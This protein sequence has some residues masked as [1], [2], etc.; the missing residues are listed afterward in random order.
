MADTDDDGVEEIE[1]AEELV[2]RVAA[3]DIAKASGMVCVRVPHEDKPGKRVQRVFNT[4]A[5]SGAI[6]DLADHLICQGVTRVVME[7]TS[8]YWKPFFFLLE[9]RGLEC[10]LVNARDVKNVPGRPKTDHLD[11]VWL[12]KLTERG[13]LR[14]S[15]VPPKPVRELRDLTRARAVMTQERTRPK[16]RTEKLLEDAQIKL[17]TVI[18][19]IFGVSGRAMLEALIAGERSPK[20]LA[21]LAHGTIKASHATLAESLTGRFEEHHAFMCRMLLDTVD[22][23]TVQIDKLTARITLRLT[24]LSTTEDDEGPGQGTLI[25]ITDTE[26]LDEIPGI[27]P[28]TAQVILAETGL[29]MTVSPTAGH[30]VSWAKLS[31][32]TLQS[33]NKNTSGPTGKGNP[34][35][36]GALGEAA[37]SAARTDTFL[38]AR[39]RRIVKRRSHMKALVAVARSILVS[40]W[41]LMND[42]TARYRDLGPDF[43]T[44]NLDP[45]RKSR[46]LVRQLKALGH[47]VTLT[48]AAA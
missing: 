25:P 1:Q 4:V 24:E 5:P 12:A 10:W 23:L 32:R 19:D 11:A 28:S 31:P 9:S 39:Y 44:R 36:R 41:H 2:A 43:H 13:M 40:V 22:Y 27:G 47:N 7:A 38:G 21:D 35:L 46:D 42:P 3:I 20:A 29:D 6:L 17:S 34:W 26:R 37:I 18:A 14:P 33:G 16:Q 45:G 8:T 15:F 30:L 48:P